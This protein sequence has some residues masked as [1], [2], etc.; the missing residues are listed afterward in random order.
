MIINVTARLIV[1]GYH[2]WPNAPPHRSYL[3]SRHRHDFYITVRVSVLQEDRQ[4]EIHDLA[5]R[6]RHAVDVVWGYEE[7]R[8]VEFGAASCETI[9]RKIFDTLV[10]ITP[11]LSDT[12]LL[13]VGVLEDNWMGAEVHS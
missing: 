13:M 11:G 8:T 9:A 4:I 10:H 3:A 5:D 1:T 7:D 2:A 6:T 12:D